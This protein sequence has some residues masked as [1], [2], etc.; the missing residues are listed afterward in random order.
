LS[1]LFSSLHLHIIIFTSKEFL[2]I[3]SNSSRCKYF[4]SKFQKKRLIVIM[5]AAEKPLST[6]T[7]SVK[8]LDGHAVLNAVADDHACHCRGFH[9]AR[10]SEVGTGT[11]AGEPT[12]E[13]SGEGAAPSPARGDG[14]GGRDV[15]SDGDGDGDGESEGEGDGLISLSLTTR[16]N[17]I[18]RETRFSEFVR[19]FLMSRSS[20]NTWPLAGSEKYA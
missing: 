1:V 5:E 19:L 16:G 12:G 20:K 11:G 15:D 13:E 9:G 2:C 3:C 7:A 8:A 14:E 18:H 10:Q 6:A 4:L 17:R